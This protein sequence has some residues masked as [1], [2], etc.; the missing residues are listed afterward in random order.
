ME[1]TVN[2]RISLILEAKKISVNKFA[3]LSGIGQKALSNM[4]LRGTSPSYKT[5]SSILR[6]YPDISSEW[7]IRGSGNMYIEEKIYNLIP[8]E[9]NKASEEAP[10]YSGRPIPFF[11][12][13]PV[14]A[15][16]NEI[17]PAKE[18]PTGFIKL[19]GVF[20]EKAFPVIGASME[21]IIHAG[22]IVVV[23]EVELW[24]RM[25][26][27]KIYLIIT[28]SDRMIKHLEKDDKDDSILCARHKKE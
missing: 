27:D 7:L 15:G 21:P 11:G 24:D 13:L 16:E 28:H 14:S 3:E 1:T 17:L 5:I 4:F 18:S 8:G 2:E 12:Q 6:I 26:P 20:G 23:T 10:Q 19:P 25:D 9:V 22:D